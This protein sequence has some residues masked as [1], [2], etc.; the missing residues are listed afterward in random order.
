M[1]SLIEYK[2]KTR[3]VNFIRT[4][5]IFFYLMLLYKTDHKTQLSKANSNGFFF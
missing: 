1:E 5:E 4:N 3:R 2:G